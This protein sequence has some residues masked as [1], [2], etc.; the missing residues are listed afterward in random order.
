MKPRGFRICL[1]SVFLAFTISSRLYAQILHQKIKE[2]SE[3]A[4]TIYKQIHRQPELGKKEFKTALLIKTN[5]EKFG[6]TD[7]R[8]IKSL[9]TAVI[10]V[11]DTKRPGKTI[12]LRAEIDARPGKEKTGLPYSSETD[13]TMHSCGHDAHTSMLLATAKL[14][15]ENQNLLA[16]RIIFIFQPAEETKGGADDIVASGILKTLGVENLFAQHS[17]GGLPVGE[18][19]ISPGFT[20]AGSNYFSIYIKGRS[21][22]AAAPFEGDD[23]P[24]ALCNLVKDLSELPARKMDISQ[25]PCVISTTY[26]E[27]GTAPTDNL[28]TLPDS[29]SFKGTIRA[30]EDI[31]STFRGQPS[32]KTIITNCIDKYCKI[33]GLFDSI[34][35]DK[36]SP[37]TFND[38]QLYQKL[39]PLLQEKFSGKIDT[40]PYKGMFSEDFSYYTNQLPCLYFGLGIA[41]DGL[42]FEPVHSNKFSVHPDAFIFGIELLTLLAENAT[43]K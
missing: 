2:A 32:I 3:F 37:P 15:I 30:Y 11:L 18:V 19:S 36:G 27:S 23:L 8:E 17:V 9:P 6:Y 33:N 10:A 35:I 39:V 43:K 20:L 41:K 16:G 22:H 24:L 7:F 5:L 42:G 14:L 40:S 1:C 26:I 12:G 31:D 21:S 4:F 34:K 38:D 28:S 13:N 25:R 29:V